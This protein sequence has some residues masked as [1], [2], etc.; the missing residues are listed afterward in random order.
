MLARKRIFATYALMVLLGVG[1]SV[2][3]FRSGQAI[4]ATSKHFLEK[5]VPLLDDISIVKVSVTEYERI[6]Y[7]YYATTDRQ[8]ML[9]RHESAHNSL[10]GAFASLAAIPEHKTALV[11]IQQITAEIHQEAARLDKTLSSQSIDWDLSREQLVKISELG[12]KITPLL[13]EMRGRIQAEVIGTAGLVESN[14]RFTTRL[15][16]VFSLVILLVAAMV[17]SYLDRYIKAQNQI[18]FLAYHDALTGLANREQF[19][20]DVAALATSDEELAVGLVKIDRFNLITAGHGYSVGDAIIRSA[21]KGL[22]RV[23]LAHHQEKIFRFDGASF[24]FIAS[25]DH[26]DS[27]IDRLQQ[28]FEQPLTA[29][30]SEFYISLGIG[31]ACYPTDEAD[32]SA[33]IQDADA[34]LSRVSREG[35]GKHLRFVEDMRMA[36]Q[37]W[38]AIENDLRFAIENNELRLFYQP[39]V[40]AKSG[41]L[42]GMEALIRW[43]SPKRGMVSPIDFIPIAEQTGLIVR[44]GE[45]VMREACEQAKRWQLASDEP[46]VVAVNIS[47]KQFL[48][49][50][51]IQTVA[52]VLTETKVDPALIE[53]EVTEGVMVE[54]TEHCIAILEELKALGI[55]LSMDDFGTGYSSLAYLKRFKIDKLKVD[56]AFIRHLP[57]DTKDL[58]IVQ[59]IIDLA[60]NLELKV[61]AEG[62]ETEEQAKWLNSRGCE[63]LQG[64]WISRPLPPAE[65]NHFFEKSIKKVRDV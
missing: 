48:H 52:D 53:F 9:S 17:A 19:E 45:W 41:D 49:H 59:T 34:A 46:C 60:H 44:I 51:F 63:E 50:H 26:V 56:Q 29:A 3:I 18:R 24:G 11:A 58:A 28:H 61:I 33:L 4:D 47:P 40:C 57:T 43:Q 12:R 54:N 38:L 62:V 64:Y 39:Q 7:E 42:L 21:A 16:G 8:E 13:D 65:L 32:V 14:T 30:N 27:F 23:A 5:N 37:S 1:L 22:E 35:G 25:T 36:E 6:L 15:V 55:F 10:E 20:L 31:Y 2:T